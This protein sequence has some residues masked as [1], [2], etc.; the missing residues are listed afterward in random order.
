LNVHDVA[1]AVR[2]A[3][4]DTALVDTAPYDTGANDNA[5]PGSTRPPV[6]LSARALSIIKLT[7]LWPTVIMLVLGF[8]RVGQPEL[9]R[10]EL[11]SWSASSRSIGDIVHLLHNTD[12]AVAL[13]YFVLHYW[14]VIFGDS[15][16]AMRSLSVL[17]MAGAAGVISLVGQRLYD[18]RTGIIAGLLFAI[19]PNVTRFA[20]E[21]RPYAITMLVAAVSTLLLLRA[22]D[23]PGWLRWVLYGLSV[24]T[25]GGIQLLALPLL[26]VHAV[27]VLL[28]WQR[29]RSRVL[30]AAVSAVAGLLLASPVIYVSNRQYDHQVGALPPATLAEI[31]RLPPRLFA[32][33]MIAGAV[34]LLAV[35]ALTK[36]FR[37]AIFCAVWAVLPGAAIWLASQGT[38]SYWM[39]RYVLIAIPGFVILAAV[40]ISRFRLSFAIVL[41]VVVAALGVQD[42]RA[43]RGPGSHDVW[44]YPDHPEDQFL[45]YSLVARTIA[46][47]MR[48]GDGIAYAERGFF[49]LNDIGM[50]YHMQGL[51]MPRDVFVARTALEVGD[52]WP[53]EC[54]DFE[55]CLH[56]EP[57]IWILSTELHHQDTPYDFMEPAKAAVLKRDY[58]IVQRWY[59]S[60][61]VGINLTLVVRKF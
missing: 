46:E 39:T 13:Y 42:Q 51:T 43:I 48:P 37:P 7:W 44:T 9:W 12:A 14:M 16:I 56:N 1:D 35:L 4:V 61:Q 60:N 6:P 19:V 40:A 17:A 45:Q 24:A 18:R 55:A 5:A 53:V 3:P 54:T 15:A 8:Y 33:G 29:D 10:D 41:V 22:L 57:R 32:S 21:V 11:R 27:A 50:T 59:P 47:N 36:Q 25:L 34:I 49:W 31:V 28:W 30:W 58:N 20:Q 26:G 52:F 2:T 23:K 38:N